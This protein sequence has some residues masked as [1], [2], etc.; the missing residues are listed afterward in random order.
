M[1][2]RRWNALPGRG[3]GA[4]GYEGMGLHKIAAFKFCNNDIARSRH[5]PP[6]PTNP[7]REHILI[8]RRQYAY[9]I[10]I[11]LQFVHSLH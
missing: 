10:I 7:L 4:F 1:A 6:H 5:Q 8:A 9:H 3:L 2:A 11:V